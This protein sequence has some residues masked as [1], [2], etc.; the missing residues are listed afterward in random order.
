MQDKI[1]EAFYRLQNPTDQIKSYVFDV[2]R[3]EVPK[4]NLDEV[5]VT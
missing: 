4:L 3:A 5:F 2:V 1:Y